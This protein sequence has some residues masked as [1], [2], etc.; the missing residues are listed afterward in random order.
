MSA[1]AASRGAAP[2]AERP[3]TGRL[4]GLVGV[5]AGVLALAYLAV[6]VV[7]ALVALRDP[8]ALGPTIV[9]L[10]LSGLGAVI[11]VTPSGTPLPLL[12]TILVIL[13]AAGIVALTAA[14]VDPDAPLDWRGWAQGAGNFLLFGLALRARIVAA[15][16]GEALLVSVVLGWSLL[17]T[18][19]VLTGVL[20]SYGQ[21]VSLLAG[22]VF[23]F[24][25]HRAARRIAAYQAQEVRLAG[26]AALE[27]ESIR[28]RGERLER[29]RGL[30]RPP[31]EAIAEG[32][33][34]AADRAEVA[35]L[36][37]ELR[38]E[39][40]GGALAGE[41]LRT[42]V[43]AA[44]GGGTDVLVLDDA[45]PTEADLAAVAEL[46][47]WAA[48]LLPTLEAPSITLRLTG[49]PERLELSVDA[50]DDVVVRAFSRSVARGRART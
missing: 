22:T 48:E 25:L 40:R 21:P 35:L 3:D 29:V 43:R 13:I 17:T 39:I 6:H 37:A 18:G 50:S 44:R 8:A 10:A 45:R 26:D 12:R 4:V 20:F 34:D 15:W 14:W 27:Q 24:G 31:L 38:D 9:A 1:P 5:G 19:S 42:P 49:T 41:P 46:R 16:I 32:R 33:A 30:V 7:T 47:G 11:L 2:A 28:R 36:E 23:S